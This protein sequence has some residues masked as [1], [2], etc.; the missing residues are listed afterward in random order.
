V[1]AL[2]SSGL[3][4]DLAVKLSDAIGNVNLI[5]AVIG[6]ASAVIDNVPLVA[7]TMGM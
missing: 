1:G 4:T 7:A 2:E 6:V 3:L 5:A